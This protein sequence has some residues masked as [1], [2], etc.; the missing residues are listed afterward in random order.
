MLLVKLNSDLYTVKTPKPELTPK[1]A[2][3]LL[4][5]EPTFRVFRNSKIVTIES[6]D[7]LFRENIDKVAFVN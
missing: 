3:P 4:F 5:G 6:E 7:S 1:K 2:Q